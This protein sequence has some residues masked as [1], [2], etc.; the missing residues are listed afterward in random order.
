[1]RQRFYIP[2]MRIAVKS[3]IKACQRCKNSKASPQVPEM[4]P[5]PIE[6]ITAFE[7]PFTYTGVDYFGPLLVTVGRR[8]EKRWGVIFTCL[9]IRGV[10]IELVSS[11]DTSA[12]ILAVRNF[13]SRKGHC[14][15]MLSDNGTNFR[16]A[17]TE[18]KNAILQ[19]DV[20][21]LQAEGQHPLPQISKME[22]RFITPRA[23]H[24]GGAWERLVRSIKTA[25]YATLKERTPKEDILR[26]VLV[27]A[28]NIVNSRPLTYKPIDPETKESITPN[29]LLQLGGQVL[30][31]PGEFS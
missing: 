28:E 4:S 24:M 9:V 23:P 17:E 29:H 1:M 30:Y 8:H 2:E 3:V 21:R 11:L 14:K 20:K 25:M 5:L 12:C 27:E 19:L 18:L 10:Y 22:W 16:G 15:L 31:S 13:L 6:R 7:K 26:N